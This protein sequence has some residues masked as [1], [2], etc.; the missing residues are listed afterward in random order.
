MISWSFV[1]YVIFLALLY[2]AAHLTRGRTQRVA[3][4]ALQIASVNFLGK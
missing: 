2:S 3:K 4:K 1:G